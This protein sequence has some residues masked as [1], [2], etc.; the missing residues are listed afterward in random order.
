MTAG[1]KHAWPSAATDAYPR[2]PSVFILRVWAE[3]GGIRVAGSIEI[4]VLSTTAMKTVFEALAERF[5]RETG[6]SLA[7]SLGPSAQLER[8]IAEGEA[9]DVAIIAQAGAEDLTARGSLVP[10]SLVAVARSSIGIAVANGAAKPDIAT[11]DAF[12]RALLAAKSIAVSKPVGG[13]Q[14]GAHMAKIFDQLGIAKAMAAKAKYGAGGAAG[15]AGLVVRRGEAELGI[16][17]MAELMAVEGI[18]VVGPLPDE[19]Q[20]VTLFTAAIPA[21]ASHPQAGRGLIDFIVT[22]AA[23]SVIKARGLEPA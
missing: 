5:E 18:D 1:A 20:S 11:P 15:L 17:Q 3:N 23:K 4:K 12:K 6:N 2:Q 22:P 10:G 7:V 21:A 9:A 13:G 19:L 8:R 16:Q 14:S